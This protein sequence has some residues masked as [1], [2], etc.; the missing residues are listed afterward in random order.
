MRS[1]YMH[2]PLTRSLPNPE[3]RKKERRERNKEEGER[4]REKGPIEK[5]EKCR[6]G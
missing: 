2:I 1:I 4:R 5:E 6:T 3:K